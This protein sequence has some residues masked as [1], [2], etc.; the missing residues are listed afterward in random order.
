MK[1]TAQPGAESQQSRPRPIRKQ[2]GVLQHIRGQ[3]EKHV[4]SLSLPVLTQAMFI[5]QNS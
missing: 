2:R 5:A 1:L 4:L 3:P